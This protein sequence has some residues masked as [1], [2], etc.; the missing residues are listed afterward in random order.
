M[1]LI[2]KDGTGGNTHITWERGRGW[3]GL[4]IVPNRPG[5][6]S[7]IWAKFDTQYR[8][9]DLINQWARLIAHELGHNMGMSHTRGG[10]MNPSIV[11][12]PFTK[13]AWRG[14]PAERLLTR[15]FGGEPI[16][17]DEPDPE[18]DPPPTG[19]QSCVIFANDGERAIR[20]D[21][22]GVEIEIT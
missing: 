12:G 13:R 22:T 5:C 19:R 11:S 7:A 8:P 14:D 17:L 20:I 16:E 9:R 6:K 18:P 2:R 21:C 1:L 15:F 10:I 3:I 4:A